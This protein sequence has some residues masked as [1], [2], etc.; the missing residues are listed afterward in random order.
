MWRLKARAG[1]GHRRIAQRPGREQSTLIHT[2][3]RTRCSVTAGAVASAHALLAWAHDA[4]EKYHL[5]PKYASFVPE[6]GLP[7][8]MS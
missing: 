4:R 6:L 7:H 3:I 5:F 2:H 8:R 1:R